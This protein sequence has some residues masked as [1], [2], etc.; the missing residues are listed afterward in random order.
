M[1][2]QRAH[3]VTD[4]G[5]GDSGKGTVTDYLVRATGSSLVIRHNGGAQAGHRVVTPDGRMHVFSQFGSGSFVPGTRT[6]L[7]KFMLVHPIAMLA[8]EE[9]LRA[10]GVGDVFERTTIDEEALVITPFQQ[11]ANRLREMAR[12]G[13]RHGSCGLGIGETMQD[14][15]SYPTETLRIRD[16]GKS[17]VPATLHRLQERKREE[18]AEIVRVL[19]RTNPLVSKELRVLEDPQAIPA[20]LEWFGDFLHRVRIVS[21]DYLR[22][23]L[24]NGDSVVFEGAQG[25]LLD[26]W[27]G[28]HPYTTWSTT[29]PANALQLLRENEYE[30]SVTSLG[31]VRAYATRHGPG[32]FVTEDQELTQKL[33]DSN[34]GMNEWQRGFRVGWFDLVAIRYALDV[35]GQI[36]GLAVTHLDRLASLTGWR[37]CE[38][39]LCGDTP[40][41]NIQAAADHDLTRQGQL[42]NLLFRCVPGYRTLNHVDPQQY[43][44]MLE[45]ELGIPV[46]IVSAGPAAQD[47]KML[48]RLRARVCA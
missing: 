27:H 47:K 29:T 17:S 33:P 3:I 40:I 36:D 2:E 22:F 48:G 1:R 21:G 20:T 41:K 35:V 6:H 45:Q 34:N 11:A 5:Y 9:R 42:T 4:L 43:L 13:G 10:V 15:I 39:Y 38:E 8:E 32:P 16:L 30:G 31:V 19:S 18:L 14:A 25:V 37:V 7:S 23:F 46:D 12:G 44:Q 26:E 24:D 28:F